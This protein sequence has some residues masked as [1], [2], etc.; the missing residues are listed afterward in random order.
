ME[1]VTDFS[2]PGNPSTYVPR[3]VLVDDGSFYPDLEM[4]YRIAWITDGEIVGQGL[5]S[6]RFNEI[7]ELGEGCG[8][9]YRTWELQCGPLAEFVRDAYGALLQERFEDWARDLKGESEVMVGSGYGR[10]L[11]KGHGRRW[12]CGEPESKGKGEGR[13]EARGRVKGKGKDKGKVQDDGNDEE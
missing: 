10:G 12:L 11:G 2:T 13:K 4:L 1:N 5:Y 7:I 6:E 3:D 8:V 9:Q